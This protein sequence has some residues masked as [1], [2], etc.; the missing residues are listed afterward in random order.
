[1][2][3]PLS[4]PRS[5]RGVVLIVGLLL[6]L[7][8]TLIGVTSMRSALLEERMTGNIQDSTVAFQA[9]EAALREGETLLQQPVLPNFDSTNGLYPPPAAPPPRWQTINWQSNNAVRVYDGFEDAP[10]SLDLATARYFIEAEPPV[11]V[12]GESLSVDT[13]VDEVGFYRVT[14]RGVGITGNAVAV[15]QSTYK[16]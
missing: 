6:L 4:P 11:L 2:R 15:L 12:P 8:L 7:V 1:M 16:R 9:A 10:G 5:Q 3:K 13:P 14:A